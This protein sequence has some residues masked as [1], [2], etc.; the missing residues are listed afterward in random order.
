MEIEIKPAYYGIST[1]KYT[2]SYFYDRYGYS[3]SSYYWYYPM[4]VTLGSLKN[5][6]NFTWDDDK[7]LFKIDGNLKD[8]GFS[9]TKGENGDLLYKNKIYVSSSNFTKHFMDVS[10]KYNHI[11]KVYKDVHIEAYA[12]DDRK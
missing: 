3:R 7:E 1:P 9:K 12:I 6:C 11:P 5:N 4:N 8:C 10:C 2:R